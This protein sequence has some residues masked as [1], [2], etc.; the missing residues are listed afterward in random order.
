M[1]TMNALPGPAP[2]ALLRPEQ[3]RLPRLYQ[4]GQREFPLLNET[5]P[6]LQRHQQRWAPSTLRLE[7]T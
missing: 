5:Q 7:T 3:A 2:Q 1:P 4:P 6:A